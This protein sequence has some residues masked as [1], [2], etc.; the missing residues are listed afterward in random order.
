MSVRICRGAAVE[1]AFMRRSFLYTAAR[2]NATRTARGLANDAARDP[3]QD[4]KPSHASLAMA[5]GG[6]GR[7]REHARWIR[8][9]GGIAGGARG[10]QGMGSDAGSRRRVPE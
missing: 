2:P 10:Q 8:F 6:A 5:G 4:R 9:A 3:R 1:G 7:A